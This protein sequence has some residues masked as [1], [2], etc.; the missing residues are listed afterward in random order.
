MRNKIYTGA[1]N[2]KSLY[3]I[4][5]PEEWN[6]KVIIFI[7]GYMGYKDWGCWNFVSDFF[8]KNNYAFLKYN[9]SHNGGTLSQ[10]VDFNDLES[11]AKNNYMKEI[12]DFEAI[13]RVVD[14]EFTS[15]PE[16]YV[17]G[18]SR[19][20]GIA[21]LHSDFG[22]IEKIAS[23]A[24]ISN[25]SDRFPKGDMLDQWK[26]DGVYF[27]ENGRTKQKMPH[28]YSQY[29]NFLRYKDRLNIENYCKNSTKP[30]LIIH[31]ENDQSVLIKEGETI[32]EWL[33]TDLVRIPNTEHTFG[34]KQPYIQL[35][36]PFALKQTCEAT[37]TFFNQPTINKQLKEKLSILSELI[38][39]SKSDDKIE[40][41]EMSFL[42]AISIQ[43]GVKEEQLGK[44]LDNP[45]VFSPN[46]S[47]MDRIVQFQ[48]MI[49]MM[50]IDLEQSSKE[51]EFIK[52]A[53]VKLGLPHEA[54]NEV[55]K[56]MKT[57][58]HS[59]ML[60]DELISIFKTFHN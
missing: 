38:Q 42:R 7:H 25:I 40:E 60:P 20:G 8:T 34:T 11:F 10:P 14:S 46:K 26:K 49:L 17:I 35:K 53:G 23:W 41:I 55:L 47:E 39:L 32:A 3:D 27:R 29:E 44:L 6:N 12:Q 4:S 43:L 9:I 1:S 52:N 36:M 31:G 18:H 48:R 24:G 33:Q 19:G 51:V 57:R 16:I 5:T 15:N 59:A 28:N 58:G 2:K 56:R 22:R 13:V 50:N 54:V 45:S 21:L 37:L 30:T